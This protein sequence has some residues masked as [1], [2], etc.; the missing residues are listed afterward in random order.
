MSLAEPTRDNLID[1]LRNNAETLVQKELEKFNAKIAER[2]A[3]NNALTEIRQ[4]KLEYE[5]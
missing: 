2:V 3:Q 1:L 4:T 5:N